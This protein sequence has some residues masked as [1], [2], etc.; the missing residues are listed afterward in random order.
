MRMTE[1]QVVVGLI[2]RR[3]EEQFEFLANTISHRNRLREESRRFRRLEHDH[4]RTGAR[5]EPSALPS[6]HLAT[7][8][9]AVRPGA[10]RSSRRSDTTR[11]RLGRS[12]PPGRHRRSLDR[13]RSRSPGSSRAARQQPS[14]PGARCR[15]AIAP[16]THGPGS[17]ACAGKLVSSR[18]R[19]TRRA[20]PGRGNES[21][22]R[23]PVATRAIDGLGRGS[24]DTNPSPRRTR[25]SPFRWT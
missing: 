4:A 23:R 21:L 25:R 10:G 2:R 12:H 17:P 15:A 14:T 8:A 3:F 22:D 20:R 16:V 13:G 7:A 11:D 5:P 6:P 18:P 9:Q 1:H 24:G 19:A